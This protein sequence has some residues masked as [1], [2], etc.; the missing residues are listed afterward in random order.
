[1]DAKLSA[2]LD[3]AADQLE[4]LSTTILPLSDTTY[5]HESQALP[6]STIGKHVRHILDHFSLLFAAISSTPSQPSPATVNYSRRERNT[7]TQESVAG[8]IASIGTMAGIARRL[9][10]QTQDTIVSDD[11]LI[12]ADTMPGGRD[13]AF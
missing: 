7:A 8:G 5:T 10:T 1:M 2:L 6:G 11:V 13:E 4:Q 3:S 9:R 12:V